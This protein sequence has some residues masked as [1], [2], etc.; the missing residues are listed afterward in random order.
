[1]SSNNKGREETA[2]SEEVKKLSRQ[3]RYNR[4]RKL[5]KEQILLFPVEPNIPIPTN[6]QH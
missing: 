3:A 5:E 1:M 2:T 4:K 6:K